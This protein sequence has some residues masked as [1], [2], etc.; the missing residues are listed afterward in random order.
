MRA[1]KEMRWRTDRRPQEMR[2]DDREAQL[3]E[4]GADNTCGDSAICDWCF[5]GF[6]DDC[7]KAYLDRQD[8]APLRVPLLE[9]AVHR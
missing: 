3:R 9:L 1:P 8:P 5:H 2:A 6:C 7:Y 4:L